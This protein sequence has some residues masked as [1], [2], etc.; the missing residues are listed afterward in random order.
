MVAGVG[1]L[2]G[3]GI[4]ML[5]TDGL[6]TVDAYWVLAF[7]CIS[8]GAAGTVL[9][10]LLGSWYARFFNKRLD[11]GGLVLWVETPDDETERTAKAILAKH[12]AE[13]IHIHDIPLAA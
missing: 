12:G 2:M 7:A 10:M 6:T 4:A 8:G 5:A 13:D 9:S 1:I 11:H 3:A